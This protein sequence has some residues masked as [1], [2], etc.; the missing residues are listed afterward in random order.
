MVDQFEAPQHTIRPLQVTA[1]P[2][3]ARAPHRSRGAT[4]ATGLVPC[5]VYG[6]A[7]DVLPFRSAADAAQAVGAVE[8]AREAGRSS[9]QPFVS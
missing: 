8:A 7:F 5:A 1:T 9:E 2:R 4:D 6:R 3:A